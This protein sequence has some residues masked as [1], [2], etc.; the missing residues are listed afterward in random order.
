[1]NWTCQRLLF[2]KSNKTFENK[3]LLLASKLIKK[4]TDP[5]NAKEYYNSYL[6]DKNTKLVKRS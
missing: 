5:A 3:L 6:N 4:I 2:N 1:M